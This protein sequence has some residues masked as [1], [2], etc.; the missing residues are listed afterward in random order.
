MRKSIIA[1]GVAGLLLTGMAAPQEK[2]YVQNNPIQ[3]GQI[4]PYVDFEPNAYWA[5]AMKW[6]VEQGI[7]KGTDTSHLNPYGTVTEAQFVTMFMRYIDPHT[8]IQKSDIYDRWFAEMPYYLADSYNLPTIG[9]AD[10]HNGNIHISRGHL[11]KL[12]GSLVGGVLLSEEKAIQYLYDHRI[13][14]NEPSIF[15]PEQTLTRAQAVTFL[16][17]TENIF[18]KRMFE[19]GLVWTPIQTESSPPPQPQNP[20]KTQLWH[21]IKPLISNFNE[22]HQGANIK[23]EPGDDMVEV[24]SG[25]RE[26][27]LF[28]TFI[29]NNRGYQFLTLFHATDERIFNLY[30]DI[31]DTIQTIPLDRKEIEANLRAVRDNQGVTKDFAQSGYSIRIYRPGSDANVLLLEWK[32]ME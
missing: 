16:Y 15:H 26:L 13:T 32:A 11:A 18:G 17:R 24:F 7:V 10:D 29:P 12:L 2:V 19:D 25:E 23:A 9:S 4:T 14:A 27:S 31:I 21:D 20:Y 28:A 1:L 30:V 5:D 3:T 6:A 22:L 8:L